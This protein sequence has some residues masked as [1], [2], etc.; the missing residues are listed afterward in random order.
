MIDVDR[1]NGAVDHGSRMGLSYR[2]IEPPL[3]REQVEAVIG[4][5]ARWI[6]IAFEEQPR[7]E[8]EPPK[9]PTSDDAEHSSL[10]R[11]L[12]AGRDAL[13]EAPPR[14]M[15][16]PGYDFAEG[17]EIRCLSVRGYGPGG[18]GANA[19]RKP[20]PELGAGDSVIIDES[21]WEVVDRDDDAL[22][23]RWPGTTWLGWLAPAG[24]VAGTPAHTLVRIQT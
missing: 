20:W 6:R 11:R 3:S 15:A 14:M 23:V 24:E 13:P 16:H 8:G 10:L 17:H 5:V 2:P 1:S 22:I 9:L 4:V 19:S 7:A 21:L 18:P 12:L